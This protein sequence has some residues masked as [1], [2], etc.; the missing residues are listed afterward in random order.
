MS[1]DVHNVVFLKS[2]Y[3]TFLWRI[4]RLLYV[5]W[6]D[7]NSNPTLLLTI[8]VWS[9]INVLF[10]SLLTVSTF[11]K[12]FS[13][14][15]TSEIT[16]RRMSVHRIIPN[17]LTMDRWYWFVVWRTVFPRL[18]G[19]SGLELMRERTDELIRSETLE[20]TRG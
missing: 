8:S 15:S 12:I 6:L 14:E 3:V 16:P 2:Y 5:A 4:F 18:E 10:K 20:K 7:E 11:D 19:G 9:I 13:P 1:H 17:R